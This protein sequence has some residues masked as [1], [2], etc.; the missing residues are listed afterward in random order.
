MTLK[1]LVTLCDE[2]VKNL[3]EINI[4]RK[5]TDVALDK[6]LVV[7]GVSV[8]ALIAEQVKYLQRAKK[9][10][11][12]YYAARCIVVGRA[13]EQSSSE[14]VA[15]A[16]DIAVGEN[17]S[18]LDLTCGLGVDVF[19]ISRV[20]GFAR[21]VAVERDEVFAAV[22]MENFRRLGAE[23][24]EVVNSSAEAFLELCVAKNER[25][26]V[27]YCDP[28]RR[29]TDGR[30]KVVLED[31]SPNI[32]A[33]QS[34]LATLSDRLVVKCSP[35]FDVD[36][37][38]KVFGAD[39]GSVSVEVVSF[40]DECKE[41]VIYINRF[42]INSSE[43][44]EIGATAVG[45]GS[46]WFSFNSEADFSS[47]IDKFFRIDEYK[48]LIIP[49]VALQKSRLA[50][51]SLSEVCDI[52]SDNGYGF[53]IE[54]PSDSI[55]GR[56]YEIESIDKYEPKSVKRALKMLGI[57]R[58]EILK[59]EFPYSTEQVAKQLG[60]KGS[61]AQKIAVTKVLEQLYVIILS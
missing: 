53:A 13:F 21:V 17:S 31:C 36:E 32:I 54:K 57:E 10:L 37:A 44:K 14:E 27:V 49:D 51:R 43:K 41:V 61:G 18:L 56:I 39:R 60:L 30:K 58:A 4:E 47:T 20:N 38:F 22:A 52:W 29:G 34:F 59:K 7:D 28:D 1:D 2:R 3:I 15:K 6:S 9:K 16:K 11:P 46:V 50:K 8:A 45:K 42:S 33:L 55:L 35:L 26:D 12:S 25:F 19:A 23:N 48:Y 5:H 40:G 24:I